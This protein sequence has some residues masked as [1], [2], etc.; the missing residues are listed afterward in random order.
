MA[1]CTLDLNKAIRE[2]HEELNKVNAVNLPFRG[3]K[4]GE[5]S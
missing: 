3:S 2:L 5:A 1:Y 4:K